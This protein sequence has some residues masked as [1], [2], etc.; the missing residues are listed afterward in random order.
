MVIERIVE[1][2]AERPSESV[3][4]AKQSRGG[5]VLECLTKKRLLKN[6]KDQT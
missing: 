6:Q 4:D 5:A 1:K 3:T 2:A